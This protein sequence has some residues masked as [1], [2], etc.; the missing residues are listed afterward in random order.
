MAKQSKEFHFIYPLTQKV[1]R[2]LRIVTEHVT[3]LHISGTAYKDTSDSAF[4]E[5]ESDRFSADV[6]CVLYLNRNIKD[7]LT[8]FNV[9]LDP[10][11][12]AAKSHAQYLF[13]IKTQEA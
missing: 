6:D 4:I 1:V 2:D 12:A 8:A 5:D 13:D 9:D 11:E 7:V 10:I 3:D